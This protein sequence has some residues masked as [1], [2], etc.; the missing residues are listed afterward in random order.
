MEHGAGISI[1]DVMTAADLALE[2]AEPVALP[3]G[4]YLRKP[5]TKK[6]FYKQR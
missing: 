4:T 1:I 6:N 2:S 5:L 3:P